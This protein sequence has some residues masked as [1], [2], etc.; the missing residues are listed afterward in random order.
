MDASVQLRYYACGYGNACLHWLGVER[1]SMSLR[2]T[3]ADC[4]APRVAHDQAM[5]IVGARQCSEG[6][7][8]A[9]TP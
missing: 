5:R 6:F 2:V 4:K 3:A 9:C 1:G 8:L 7:T